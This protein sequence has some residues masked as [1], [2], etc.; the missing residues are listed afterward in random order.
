MVL[1]PVLEERR[2]NN[3]SNVPSMISFCVIA[4]FCSPNAIAQIV[5]L[6]DFVDGDVSTPVKW[7]HRPRE[8][9][10]YHTATG[11]LVFRA[12]PGFDTSDSMAFD[13]VDFVL[14][15][16]SAVSQIR[17]SG[18]FAFVGIGG[19]WN[20]VDRTGY[21]N[22]LTPDGTAF[23]GICTPECA[24][25]DSVSTSFDV[26][27]QDV[28]FRF[29]AV[30]TTLKSWFWLPDEPMPLEPLL[31][32]EHSQ[33]QAGTPAIYGTPLPENEV[34]FRFV[35]VFHPASDC[36]G[37]GVISLTDADC[38]GTAN[39]ID[40][41]NAVVTELG[42]VISD[43]DGNGE[44]GFS[45]FLILAGNFGAE[46]GS[47]YTMG[48]LNFDGAVSFSDFLAF[49]DDFGNAFPMGSVVGTI[50]SVP[51]PSSAGWLLAAVAVLGCRS[52]NVLG[53]IR[54]GSH[55]SSIAKHS[56]PGEDS[57]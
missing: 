54:K 45:D 8:S 13:P 56:S 25:L 12:L 46:D 49:T 36:N 24:F 28:M 53:P 2:Y 41:L 55:R 34:T 11:D 21:F 23:I 5:F 4:F 39:E 26:R 7:A 48:D 43:F 57:P 1:P 50:A 52:W 31:T 14:E 27:H 9:G 47:T 37:D 3:W 30:G 33:Y 40:D 44:V 6:D 17:A 19:R 42:S 22:G 29:D 15:D 38:F 35:N 51:E 10:E 32:T 18:D 16:S 20:E